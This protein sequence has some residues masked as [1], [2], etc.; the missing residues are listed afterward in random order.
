MNTEPTDQA[1]PV[2][3][4]R[5]WHK[6]SLVQE[7]QNIL[8]GRSE[9]QEGIL[10]LA[11][12]LKNDEMKFGY[13]RKLLAK[14]R[15]TRVETR[16]LRT[17]LCQQHALCTYK[18]PDL[19]AHSRLDLALEILQECE[20]LKETEDQETLG[21]AGAIFKRKWEVDAQRENLDRSLSYYLRGYEL[22]PENDQGYTGINAAFVLDKLA[23][24]EDAG[25]KKT[26]AESEAAQKRRSQAQE[27]RS[28]LAEKLPD[29][30]KDS[31][32]AWLAD[33]WWFYATLA[34]SFFGLAHYDDAL[35]WL[36]EGKQRVG[37]V[38]EWQKRSTITQFTEIALLQSPGASFENFR[39][40]ESARV[41]TEFLENDTAGILASAYIG[42]VGL[43]LS[44]G[45]FRASLYHIGVLARLAELGILPH[46]EVLS[47]VSGGSIVG[48]HYYLEL[49]EL[50]KQKED[51]EIDRKDYIECVERLQRDFLAGVQ[52]NIR[53]RI[54]A[55]FSTNLKMIFLPGYSRTMRA[56]DLYERFLYSKVKDDL[57]QTPRWPPWKRYRRWLTDLY[58]L[59]KDEDPNKFRPKD[60][61]WRRVAKVPELILNA[62]SL[63]TGHNWQFTASWM[64]EPP[65]SVDTD[66]DS[67]YR[68]RR[69]YYWEAP[70]K[71][72]CVRL[73]H[74]VAASACVP[75]LFEPLSLGKL[76]PDITVRLVDGGVH[77]NQGVA[78]LIEQDCNV[79]LIS[80][81][82]GQMDTQDE[83]SLGVLGVP[84]RSNSI[85]MDRVRA[86][87]Y[88]EVIAR[89]SSG[90]LRGLM[91]VHLKKD[92]NA[93]PVDWLECKDPYEASDMARPAAERGV[94]TR[95]GIR[96]DVQRML[97]G[98]RTDLDSFTEAEAYALMTSGY[99]MTEQAFRDEETLEVFQHLGKKPEEWNWDFLKVE[100][101]MQNATQSGRFM[102]ILK[103]A[104]QRAFKIWQ[105]W[106]PLKILAWISLMLGAAGLVWLFANTWHIPLIS[107][108][109]IGIAGLT[110]VA[111]MIVGKWIVRVIRFRD[112]L[113]MIGIG[114]GLAIVGP[115]LVRLH[116][117]VFDRLYLWW[118]KVDKIVKRSNSTVESLNREEQTE[119]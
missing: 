15:S 55:E 57:A 52:K 100:E 9:S 19:P 10:D 43:A 87:Q 6:S 33:E 101:A 92:L 86:E 84:L 113:L 50:L 65:G 5:G 59:P 60:H 94:L 95:Y 12:K 96:K 2:S 110:G 22:G 88:D 54:A 13:A 98:I 56:G 73:G 18:D 118:G 80:D 119:V 51:S 34:E 76:Y 44:G 61:N 117:S 17:K 21:L 85:L 77:D 97:A 109:T 72:Q 42:K 3:G 115:I 104:S 20:D 37:K 114:V 112:T 93:D 105:L 53:T 89:N 63:N 35:K 49:R 111:S 69:M 48:A 62:T 45:G 64:G 30:L 82:S 78:G 8:R 11:M 36:K 24:L 106:L 91:Y 90:L 25:A 26:G 39:L 4:P 116:L 58:I 32:N 47:C 41:L 71:Y 83:P 102:R 1:R 75:G 46:V 107:V 31:K 29:L 40:S 108:K 16:D 14:A 23:S 81:A 7:A 79:L 38:P 68:L 99:R 74:A 103:V 67:N 70:E 28:V 27:I 66:I